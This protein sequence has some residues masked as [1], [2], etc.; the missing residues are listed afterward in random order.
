[1][2]RNPMDFPLSPEEVGALKSR[3][4]VDPLDEP[5]RRDLVAWYRRNGHID[6]A[7]R[8]AVAI[9][10]LATEEETRAYASMLRGLRADY[11]L[12]RE[13]SRLPADSENA[14]RVS[15]ELASALT[16][17]NRG[18]VIGA[19]AGWT[20]AA[21]GFAVLVTLI[22][23]YVT[24]LRG[25][26]SAQE[27]AVMSSSIALFIGAF[28]CAATTTTFALDR[29]RAAVVFAVLCVVAI[30]LAILLLIG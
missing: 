15:A 16:M 27:T 13:L 12:M 26:P 23:T 18:G 11:L 30:T 19:I 10:G 1:M 25:E 24:T 9:E 2:S 14:A 4:G 7:G 3:L 17:A 5:A 20:W 29:S 22:A 28:A 6:Q 21:F 8:F